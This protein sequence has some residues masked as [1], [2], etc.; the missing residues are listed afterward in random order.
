VERE[1]AARPGMEDLG[2][3]G[4][5]GVAVAKW[6]HSRA[7]RVGGGGALTLDGMGT[8]DEL[9][10]VAIEPAKRRLRGGERLR[11]AVRAAEVADLVERG[12][13]RV[14]PRRIEVVDPERVEDRRL[15]NVLHSLGTADPA[16]SL[17]EWLR[18][19]PRSLT[20]EYLS[21]LEDQRLIRVRRW[22]DRGGR[23]HHDI[24]YVN[25]DRRRKLLE[26]MDQEDGDRVL[27]SLVRTAGLGSVAYP[28]LR[29]RAARRRL[30]ARA[31]PGALAPALADATRAADEESAA[32]LA[33]GIDTF[34]R[35]LFGELADIYSDF[36]TG[37]HGLSHDLDSGGW[38]GGDMGGG[39]HGGGHHGGGHHGGDG[40]GG[41]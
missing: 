35:R 9:V 28:G 15:N 31:E 37:G 32:G 27:A 14:G 7:V 3:A 20:H 30:A 26:R 13:V 41:W 40:H 39:H 34:P 11:F 4:G 5:V 17:K 24:L 8:G 10:L 29:G 1:F 23:T 38:S 12:R 19:T 25:A 2:R 21:R 16:P 33:E 18:A 6:G 22:R 36:S